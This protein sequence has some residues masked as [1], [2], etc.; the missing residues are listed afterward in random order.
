MSTKAMPMASRKLTP[1][2]EKPAVAVRMTGLAMTRPTAVA[3]AVGKPTT[4][5]SRWACS[6]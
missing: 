1:P 2:I 6:R 3:S 4:P 5:W